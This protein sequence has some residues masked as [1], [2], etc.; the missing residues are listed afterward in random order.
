MT[1]SIRV[2]THDHVGA[3]VYDRDGGA[4]CAACGQ[5]WVIA[6]RSLV[7]LAYHGAHHARTVRVVDATT[8][9]D[10]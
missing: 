2:S 10:N 9:T 5:R 4:H 6:G 3:M 8:I 1:V 7:P